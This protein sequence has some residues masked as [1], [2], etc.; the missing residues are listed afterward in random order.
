[1]NELPTLEEA[2]VIGPAESVWVV[3]LML[4][5]DLLPG[6]KY[7]LKMLCVVA[8]DY[9]EAFTEALRIYYDE[10]GN[11]WLV[12]AQATRIQAT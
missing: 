12:D 8:C 10:G 11:G 1:M 3:A 4:C 9:E 6:N 5:T 2:P 7:E